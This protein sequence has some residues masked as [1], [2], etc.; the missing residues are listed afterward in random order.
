MLFRSYFDTYLNEEVIKRTYW[1]H[2]TISNVQKG[3]PQ[4][5][6]DIEKLEWHTLEN[7]KNCLANTYETIREVIEAYQN[8]FQAS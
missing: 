7:S 6:E 4:V 2:M 8:K 5:L 1:F 3:D